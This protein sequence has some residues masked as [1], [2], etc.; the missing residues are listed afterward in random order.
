MTDLCPRILPRARGTM[1]GFAPKPCNYDI[2]L[3]RTVVE[4][5]YVIWHH[6]PKTWPITSIKLEITNTTPTFGTQ[7]VNIISVSGVSRVVFFPVV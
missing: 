4:Q 7:T 5:W 3:R 6:I 2:L 1:G